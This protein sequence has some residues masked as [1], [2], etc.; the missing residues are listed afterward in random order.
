[1]F[2]FK[3]R[4]AAE[5]QYHRELARRRQLTEE[6]HSLKGNIRVLCRVRPLFVDGVSKSELAE[7]EDKMRVIPFQEDRV[8]W[9]PGDH[10]KGTMPGGASGVRAAKEF[11]F[12]RV[13]GPQSLQEEVFDEVAGLVDSALDGYKACI[14][15]YGQTGSGKTF[16]M[17][18]PAGRDHSLMDK[19]SGVT[20]RALHRIFET[21]HKQ[22]QQR[23]WTWKKV[24]ISMLEVYK[25][26][27]LDLL[28]PPGSEQTLEIK[29]L[30][31]QGGKKGEVTMEIA[32][33][34]WEEVGT[35][36]SAMKLL[37]KGY[38]QRVTA[39]TLM[40]S[41]SSRSHL[42]VY[43]GLQ[44][45]HPASGVSKSSRL[46]LVD[47]AGSERISRSGAE[48][49]QLKEAQAI[50]KSLSSL[51]DVLHALQHKVR[52]MYHPPVHALCTVCVCV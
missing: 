8:I 25:E 2:T 9:H 48:G 37:A 30:Q 1:M 46:C 11:Q 15:A 4:D 28:S 26:Q 16:T 42:L 17:D 35:F 19:N 10:E 5:Q 45:F 38:S 22:A 18:G 3:E 23:D 6:V 20:P 27:L 36:E 44:G 50:N 52:K 32:G 43:L 13:F 21:I 24:E 12:N 7:V 39:A 14:F 31:A 34:T 29:Q 49:N 47:L 51:G 40:N 41:H 33:L